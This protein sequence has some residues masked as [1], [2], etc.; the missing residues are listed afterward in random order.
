MKDILALRIKN[1][2]AQAYELLFRKYYIRLCNFSNKFLHNQEESS[3]I[4]EEVFLKIWENRSE[5]D[6]DDSILSFMFKIAQNS[7]LNRLRRKKIESKYIE[8]LKITYI[9]HSDFNAYDSYVMNE[10]ESNFR[11]A[12]DKIPPQSK[13]VFELSR[14]EGLK[15]L[16]IAEEMNIS[17]RTVE[18]HMTKALKILR[19]ELADYL[20]I[21]L[22]ITIMSL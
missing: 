10:L 2:D 3:E 1:G 17:V 6:P 15:Y 4:A 12:L 22:V 21:M 18:V 19:E 5:I 11:L 8:V 9:E 14:F 16:Q 20:T 7:S 13:R